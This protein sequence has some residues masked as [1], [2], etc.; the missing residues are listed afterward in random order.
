LPEGRAP[1]GAR[2]RVDRLLVNFFYAHPVGHAIEALH[3]ANGYHAADPELEIAV[4]LNAATPVE[5]AA[6]CPC[7]SA[8][9]AI[10]QPLLEPATPSLD[11]VPREWT[12]VVDDGRRHQ[13][14]QLGMFPG[15]RDYYAA[16]DEHLIAHRGRRPIGYPPPAYRPHQPLRLVLPDDVRAAGAARLGDREGAAIALMPAG[17][18]ERAL[19]P[20]LGSRQLFLD[21]LAD[22]FPGVRVALVGRLARDERTST[23]LG[24]GELAALLAHRS[25]PADCFDVPLAEQLAVVEASDVF[26]S[27]HTGFGLAALAVGTPWL[28]ISGGRWFEYYFNHV[29]FRSIVPDTER[30]P[31]YAQFAPE[32]GTASMS[33]P[34]IRADLD[35]IVAAAGELIAGTLSYEDALRDYF[36]DL[37]A[38]HRGDASAIWSID[39]VHAAYVG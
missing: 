2:S 12:W 7:V 5:L 3:Y 31:S 4:A 21:A 32:V 38:A 37:V 29:P 17:S 16:S 18:S 10:E 14:I 27:P 19:Y 13:D 20:S 39:G 36:A 6:F 22:A 9:Y 15:L 23:S 34:R 30:Y 11:D 26:L 8:A 1:N 35:R 33:E 28:T 24:A 25:R